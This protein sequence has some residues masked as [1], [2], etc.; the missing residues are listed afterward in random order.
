MVPVGAGGDQSDQ[1]TG[2]SSRV[3][4]CD[5]GVTE[6]CTWLLRNKGTVKRS[7]ELGV[8]LNPTELSCV[9]P[10]RVRLFVLKFGL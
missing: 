2:G 4:R 6:S 1:A 9:G 8:K 10:L 5:V 7:P 3:R